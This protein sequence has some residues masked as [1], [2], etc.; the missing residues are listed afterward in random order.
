[1]VQFW[2]G[3]HP[4]NSSVNHFLNQLNLLRTEL[5]LS[6]LVPG[7]LF[8][9]MLQL[10]LDS[11]PVDDLHPCVDLLLEQTFF[12]FLWLLLLF[13]WVLLFQ[14]IISYL[15]V[16]CFY[17]VRWK[18]RADLIELIQ[19][20]FVLILKIQVFPLLFWHEPLHSPREPGVMHYEWYFSFNFFWL[21]F[22]TR[23]R[24]VLLAR[25]QRIFR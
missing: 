12:V 10:H 24:V 14:L 17:D 22:F 7:P 16:N 2:V 15:F 11:L 1:M 21:Y 25:G 20:F 23:V 18:W 4:V 13:R 9:E 5:T 19:D 3:S 6:P 8:L